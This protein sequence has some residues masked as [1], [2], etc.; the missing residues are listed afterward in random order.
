M[1]PGR[2][3]GPTAARVGAIRSASAG[4]LTEPAPEGTG[5]YPGSG[6][7]GRSGTPRPP[8]TGSGPASSGWASGELPAR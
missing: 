1:R 3:A 8:V 7:C 5:D 4:Q 2:T 6:P